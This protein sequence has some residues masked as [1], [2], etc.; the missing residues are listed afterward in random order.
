M[1]ARTHS[2]TLNAI[3]GV[4]QSPDFQTL[5]IQNGAS[6]L[7]IADIR[8]GQ[9]INDKDQWEE[10][11]TFDA[12]IKHDDVWIDGVQEAKTFEFHLYAL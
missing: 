2:D 6:I 5:L 11:P 12:V 1:N 4:M 3:A 10:N 9:V 8:M 7:R